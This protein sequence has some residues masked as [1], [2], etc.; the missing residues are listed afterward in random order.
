MKRFD[1]REAVLAAL[2]QKGLYNNYSMLNYMKLNS[3][4]VKGIIE[5]DIQNLVKKEKAFRLTLREI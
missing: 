5:Q 4:I 3:S 1:A 2:K